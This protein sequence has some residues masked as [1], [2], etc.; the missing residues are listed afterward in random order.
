M[1][2][3]DIIKKVKREMGIKPKIEFAGEAW[4]YECYSPSAK[5]F[6]PREGDLNEKITC[7]CKAYGK[8]PE[9]AYNSWCGVFPSWNNEEDWRL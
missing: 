8:T 9:D 7:E 2:M 5:G 3:D 6:H 4:G 1:K